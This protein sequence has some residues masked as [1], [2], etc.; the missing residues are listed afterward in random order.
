[1]PIVAQIICDNCQAVEKHTNHCY[2]IS[3][4]NNNFSL[5]PLTLTADWATKGFP[6]PSLQYFCGR[7]CAVEALTR[8]MN[9]LSDETV[10]FPM[11]GKDALIG[12][13]SPTKTPM[14]NP[15]FPNRG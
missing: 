1:M 15:L 9:K 12:H 13:H 10:R 7:F 5:K 8:W 6:D 4:E 11:N 2:A 14:R 3:L